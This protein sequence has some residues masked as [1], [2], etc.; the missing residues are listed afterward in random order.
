MTKQSYADKLQDPRW[1]RKRLKILERDKFK[2][3]K[4]GDE[5]TTLHVHHKIY[6]KGKDPWEYDNS[7]LITLCEDC[8]KVIEYL[9]KELEIIF[10]I[11]KITIGKLTY[12]DNDEIYLFVFIDDV[13]IGI[14]F[15][16]EKRIID[17]CAIPKNL[18][19]AIVKFAKNCENYCNDDLKKRC[20][21]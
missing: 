1:Q 11:N 9:K 19:R 12:H 10:D 13:C 17:K 4:C 2:C 7:D 5:E 20:K 14:A 21:K 15:S 8:H 18:F 6:K 16:K 3:K